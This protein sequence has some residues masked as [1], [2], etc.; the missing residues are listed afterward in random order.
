MV[1]PDHEAYSVEAVVARTSSESTSNT[2]DTKDF[3]K[4][5]TESLQS[6]EE[7]M[8][9]LL[10]EF[11]NTI[12]DWKTATQKQLVQAKRE[13]TKRKSAAVQAENA[14]RMRR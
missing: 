1:Y 14:K 6:H 5:L 13:A 4:V 7:C 3:E 9:T 2:L 11:N 8:G 10:E 12:D